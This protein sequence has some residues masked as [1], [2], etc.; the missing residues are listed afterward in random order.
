M[1][2]GIGSKPTPNRNCVD[3]AYTI[4]KIIQVREDAG[5]ATHCSFL[6]AQT[7]MAQYGGKGFGESCGKLGSEERCGVL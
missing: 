2:V 6:D 5:L 3:H 4:G 1:K 7:S